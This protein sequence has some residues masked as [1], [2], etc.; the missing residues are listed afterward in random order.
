M[1]MY[2]LGLL[3]ARSSEGARNTVRI[4]TTGTSVYVL[5]PLGSQR[6]RMV[7]NEAKGGD[8]RNVRQGIVSKEITRVDVT[9]SVI[10]IRTAF[11]RP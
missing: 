2:L 4:I 7:G 10:Q 3:A 11:P 5:A 9:L 8:G 6:C 1:S